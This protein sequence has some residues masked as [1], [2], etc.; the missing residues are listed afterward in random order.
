VVDQRKLQQLFQELS[1]IDMLSRLCASRAD[2]TS[3]DH[4]AEAM[5]RMRQ[6]ELLTEIEKLTG[7]KHRTTLKEPKPPRSAQEIQEL[8][9]LIWNLANAVSGREGKMRREA[10]SAVA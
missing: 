5:R 4:Y 7:K 6:E 8:A 3:E 10:S 2:R 1:S 9:Q